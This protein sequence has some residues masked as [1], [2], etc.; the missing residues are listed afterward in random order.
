VFGKRKKY[1]VIKKEK[2]RFGSL[3]IDRAEKL[4]GTH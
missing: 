4:G 2:E 3:F 1:I